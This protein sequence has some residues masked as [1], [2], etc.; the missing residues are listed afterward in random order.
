MSV[1]V[2]GLHRYPGVL[3]MNASAERERSIRRRVKVA[4]GLVLF[5]TLTYVPGGV[6]NLPS[7]FGKFLP[8]GAL[9]LAILLALSVNPKI[10]LR[11]NVFLSL[12]GLLVFDAIITAIQQKHLG[13]YYR[14]FRYIEFLTALWLLTPWWGRSDMML[15]RWHLRLLYVLLIVVG[16]GILISPGKAFAFG[17]RLSGVVWPMG[18]TQ[19]A[20][21]GGVAAGLTILLWLGRRIS[22]RAAIIG[23]AFSLLILLLT[24]TRTDLVALGAGILVAGISLFAV[25]ARVRRF[26]GWSA[27]IASMAVVTAAGFITTWLARGEGTSGLVTLTG[28]TNFWALVLNEPRNLFQEI[29]GFGITN[30]SINGLPID[31]NWLSS[32]QQEGL[33]GVCVCALMVIFLIVAAF[34]QAPGMRRSIILFLATYC[35]LDSFTEDAFEAPSMYLLHLTIAASLLVGATA[36]RSEQ[37][38]MASTL[39]PLSRVPGPDGRRADATD[40]NILVSPEGS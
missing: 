14:T 17:G 35:L 25:N 11:P 40:I 6:I 9:P 36:L 4:Y 28:R 21:Y 7:K 37:D 38:P 22:G 31:S 33:F 2:A 29:F 3:R 24:H 12:V 10:K 1:S 34:F 32:Y 19:V 5:N 13:T 39:K 18:P 26:F 27:L 23:T 8:N 16:I 20:Q 30:A 15:F